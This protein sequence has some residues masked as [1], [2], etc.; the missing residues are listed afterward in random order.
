M[1][2]KYNHVLLNQALRHQELERQQA[3]QKNPDTSLVDQA[4]VNAARTFKATLHARLEES[5]TIE[6]VHQAIQESLHEVFPPS[7]SKRPPHRWLTQTLASQLRTK[8][9]MWHEVLQVALPLKVV[10]WTTVLKARYRAQGIAAH[11]GVEDLAKDLNTTQQLATQLWLKWLTWRIQHQALKRAVRD[12]KRALLE[13]DV[14]AAQTAGQRGD[15]TGLWKV[16]R[17]MTK[18]HSRTYTALQSHSGQQ[19]VTPE[20]ELEEIQRFMQATYLTTLPSQP[21]DLPVQAATLYSKVELRS[22]L[23]GINYRKAV[24]KWSAAT[25]AWILAEEHT[26]PAMQRALESAWQTGKY[27][28]LWTLHHT[29]WIPKPGKD[30]SRIENLRP[31]N[32]A[33]PSLKAYLRILQEQLREHLQRKW[34]PTQY[35]AIPHRGTSD[36]L[37]VVQEIL[38]RMRRHKVSHMAFVGD[39]TRAFDQLSRPKLWEAL[40]KQ[41]VPEHL[42][43]ELMLRH[44]DVQYVS[45]R[46]DQETSCQ[47]T[48]GVAQGDPCGPVLFNA[49]YLDFAEDINHLRQDHMQEMSFTLPEVFPTVPAQAIQLHQHL[50]VDDHLEI[51]PV[52]ST[53][54]ARQLLDPILDTQPEYGVQANFQKTKL[55]LKMMGKGSR[56]VRKEFGTRL[57]CS[58]GTLTCASSAKYLGCYLDMD[59]SLEREVSYRLKQAQK[60]HCA[61]HRFWRSSQLTVQQKLN[62]YEATVTAVLLYGSETMTYSDHQLQRMEKLRTRHLRHITISPVH[63]HG[64]SNQDLRIQYGRQS[65]T[66]LLRERRLSFARRIAIR[67]QE[68]LPVLAALFGHAP[69]DPAGYN[70]TIHSKWSCLL[71]KDLQALSQHPGVP[72]LPVMA[73]HLTPAHLHWLGQQ[74][75]QAIRSARTHHSTAD[76]KYKLIGPPNAPVH[77][78]HC[79]VGFDTLAKLSVHK[80]NAH[81]EKH[82]L[83]SIVPINI[84][85]D[86]GASLEVVCPLCKKTYKNRK[87]AQNHITR[88]CAPKYTLQEQQQVISDARVERPQGQRGLVH[89]F[90]PPR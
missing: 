87:T 67:P 59:G 19:C 20:E 82:P 84:C 13:E 27:P 65:L 81:K 6:Q 5:P 68:H 76:R 58:A 4:A 15:Q 21:R 22:A 49:T 3:Q 77:T 88:W 26:V 1:H 31:I 80:Y 17:T 41:G 46:E 79:G 28:K 34:L 36:A 62:L 23:R 61:L 32:L 74:P 75:K 7:S 53:A 45:A 43:Q 38:A 14:E 60:A 54:H 71:F 37:L 72:P 83:R 56:A 50:F 30:P 8:A 35:G 73:Q 86:T 40:R 25:A 11:I 29:V 48:R 70:P 89:F 33:D 24:P 2:L 66:S 42:V 55:G 51:W 12:A 69:W 85:P 16:I 63:L 64:I 52:I 57:R 78:C 9:A 10:G 44:Q 47:S 18:G 39:A 90:V